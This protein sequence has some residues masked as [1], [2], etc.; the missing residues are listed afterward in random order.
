MLTRQRRRRRRDE[1]PA[2]D[3]GG[4]GAVQTS[5]YR[6]VLYE[7]WDVSQD[8]T[9]VPINF[10]A[11]LSEDTVL[12]PTFLRTRRP[13]RSH[14]AHN[15]TPHRSTVKRVDVV[16]QATAVVHQYTAPW[17]V[18]ALY[19][20]LLDESWTADTT[21][22]QA[23]GVTAETGSTGPWHCSL[24][25]VNL[26]LASTVIV[27]CSTAVAS[28]ILKHGA[29]GQKGH[30]TGLTATSLMGYAAA[31]AVMSPVFKHLTAAVSTNT[32]HTMTALFFGI[33]VLAFDYVEH[34]DHTKAPRVSAGALN[35]GMFGTICLASRMPCSAHAF[36]LLWTA[37]VLFAMWPAMRWK[38]RHSTSQR[39]DAVLAATLAVAVVELLM[40][41]TATVLATWFVV[42]CGGLWVA[43][44]ALYCTLHPL[45]R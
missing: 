8:D 32:I 37:V 12:D 20:V 2:A 1:P 13:H 29:F 31:L 39:G 28:V 4:G 6:K 33:N 22:P 30:G 9:A 14:T 16:A 43:L 21:Q 24:H 40:L 45:K 27:L 19:Y 5:A 17:I 3:G 35:A 23:G 34:A 42:L 26:D 25:Y 11:G 10:L 36:A 15:T 41:T 7:Q 44:P 38:I 18:V